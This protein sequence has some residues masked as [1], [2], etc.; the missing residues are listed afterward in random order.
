MVLRTEKQVVLD[1]VIHSTRTSIELYLWVA[2][3]SDDEQL[4]IVLQM[5]ASHR[6]MLVDEL[7]AEMY[8][9]GDMPS[10]PDPEKLAVEEVLARI[11]ATFSEDEKKSLQASL[12]ELDSQL[13]QDIQEALR[14]DFEEGTLAILAELQE[15]VAEAVRKR[16]N[17]G[18]GF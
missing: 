15:S 1:T 4:K 12:D 7:A 13:L 14:L 3:S 2:D 9:L 16:A 8:G 5:L 17:P 6:E 11:K 10:S 18:S